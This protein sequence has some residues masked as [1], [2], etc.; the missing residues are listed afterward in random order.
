[1]NKSI[2]S[3]RPFKLLSV[4]LQ[5]RERGLKPPLSPPGGGGTFIENR[6]WIQTEVGALPIRSS[7]RTEWILSYTS[8]RYAAASRIVMV[9]A[10]ITTGTT[11][12]TFPN[13]N[14]NLHHPTVTFGTLPRCMETLVTA[15]TRLKQ[16]THAGYADAKQ[17]VYACLRS[18]PS[19]SYADA[20]QGEAGS[21]H[22][23]KHV[24][25]LLNLNCRENLHIHVS[26][27]VQIR[28]PPPQQAPRHMHADLQ[29]GIAHP[30][31]CTCRQ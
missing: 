11:G 30:Y 20:F 8:W 21:L 10:F 2:S 4:P 7:N 31:T 27:S 1:M 23:Y 19:G 3:D 18:G 12:T 14:M 5:T 28:T 17:Y 9:S 16:R 26:V 13:S 22:N 29:V 25:G 15:M 6:Y 24:L